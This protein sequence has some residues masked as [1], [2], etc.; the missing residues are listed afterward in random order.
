MGLPNSLLS[1]PAHTY[2]PMPA[3][4]KGALSKRPE[5]QLQHTKQWFKASLHGMLIVTSRTATYFEYLNIIENWSQVPVST[6]ELGNMNI[7]TL[8]ICVSAFIMHCN[9]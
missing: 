4:D 7:S 6:Q 9:L 2:N 1:P 3:Y 8:K 5:G